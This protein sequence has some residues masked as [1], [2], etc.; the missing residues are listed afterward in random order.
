MIITIK[1]IGNI[2]SMG[3]WDELVDNS[4]ELKRVLG[5]MGEIAA[6]KKQASSAQ[7]L[8]PPATNTN[9]TNNSSGS[10]STSGNSMYYTK[11]QSSRTLS[12]PSL[13]TTPRPAGS[14]SD[15]KFIK[16]ESKQ[17]GLV[18][19]RIY[20]YYIKAGGILFTSTSSSKS[21][22]IITTITITISIIITITIT[23]IISI[24]IRYKHLHGSDVVVLVGYGMWNSE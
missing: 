23:I 15:G 19:W 9:T 5:D 13:V 16:G 2:E 8:T 6:F 18:S 10:P 3:T 17:Q 1:I 4:E 7:L 24:I 22:L 11:A 12:S 20:W 21:F 14:E